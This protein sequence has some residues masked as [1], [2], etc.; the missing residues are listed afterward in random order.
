MCIV[1]IAGKSILGLEG[2]CLKL[3]SNACKQDELETEFFCYFVE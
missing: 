1:Q 3:S 2:E